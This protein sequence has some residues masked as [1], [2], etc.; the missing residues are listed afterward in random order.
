M[1]KRSLYPINSIFIKPNFIMEISKRE[2]SNETR[3]L[4]FKNFNA[5]FE[6]QLPEHDNYRSAFEAAQEKVGKHYS[7]YESF[8]SSRTQK[9][10][11]K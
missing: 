6:R 11:R 1:N 5:E 7:S 2:Y 3:I 8:K 9:R 4:P 10:R